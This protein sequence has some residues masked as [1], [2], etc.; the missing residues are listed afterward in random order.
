MNF[1]LTYTGKYIGI[2]KFLKKFAGPTFTHNNTNVSS[3]VLP[4]QWGRGIQ[5]TPTSS[6]AKNGH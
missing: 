2:I 1:A 5:L 3:L 4:F 6:L